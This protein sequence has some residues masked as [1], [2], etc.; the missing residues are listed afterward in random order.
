MTMR[1]LGDGST[2][3]GISTRVTSIEK[4]FDSLREDFGRLGDNLARQIE[5]IA[6]T[7]RGR[8]TNWG[9]IGTIG[10]VVVGALLTMGTQALQPLYKDVDRHDAAIELIK[11]NA[12]TKADASVDLST[13]RDR[14]ARDEKETEHQI[15]QKVALAQF[16]EFKEGVLTE[17]KDLK[18][19]TDAIDSNLVKRPEIE[20]QHRTA[21]QRSDALS[22]RA[23]TMQA[24]IDS[25][26]PASK[27]IDEMW[28]QLREG[29]SQQQVA[30]IAPIA[31]LAPLLPVAPR[32]Q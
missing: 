14:F 17:I 19:R 30:P 25:F 27:I 18:T 20:A 13:V 3:A 22:A 24:Q 12:Y 5:N 32:G 29:R 6:T 4:G 15:D 8:G 23:N 26:F 28:A 31:P 16:S 10:G 7:V 2:L 9:A 1:D 21:D 11:S